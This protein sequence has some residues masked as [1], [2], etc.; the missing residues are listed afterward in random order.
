[1]LQNEH[2]GANI[3]CTHDIGDFRDIKD[4]IVRVQ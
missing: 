1:M 4:D 2:N 3:H